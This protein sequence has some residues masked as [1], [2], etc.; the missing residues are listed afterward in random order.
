MLPLFSDGG[1]F[2]YFFFIFFKRIRIYIRL[3]LKRIKSKSF[4]S[5]FSVFLSEL[6]LHPD[7]SLL[8]T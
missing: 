8:K 4:E 1:G 5:T 2:F 6:I 7:T 3:F